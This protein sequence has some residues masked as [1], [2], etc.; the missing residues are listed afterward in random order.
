MQTWPQTRISK[1]FNIDVPIVQGGMVWVSGAKLVAAVAN[2]GCLGLIGAG[3][4]SPE[5]L[6]QHIQ[7]AKLLTK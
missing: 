6:R 7:K 5:L 3:S 1:L 4:M 2:S